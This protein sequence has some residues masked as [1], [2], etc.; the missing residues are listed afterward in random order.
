MGNPFRPKQHIETDII[1]S[2]INSGELS[3]KH[4]TNGIVVVF[5]YNVFYNCLLIVWYSDA[6]GEFVLDKFGPG[7]LTASGRKFIMDR[8][9]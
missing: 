4:E 1:D 3:Y 8:L 7:N 5:Q 9:V 6:D 2:S